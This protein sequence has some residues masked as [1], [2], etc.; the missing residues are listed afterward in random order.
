[1]LSAPAL[2]HPISIRPPRHHRLFSQISRI[3][4]RAI[5]RSPSVSVG[6]SESKRSACSLCFLYYSVCFV[7]PNCPYHAHAANAVGLFCCH[8]KTSRKPAGGVRSAKNN[9]PCRRRQRRRPNPTLTL[10]LRG[11]VV[12]W[13]FCWVFG[14]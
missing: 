4:V 1:M 9:S 12:G 6:R 8:C 5:A 7:N 13:I 2:F 11:V 10:R 14:Y 3:A